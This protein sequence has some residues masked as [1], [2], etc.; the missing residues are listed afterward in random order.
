[1][2]STLIP[3]FNAQIQGVDSIYRGIKGDTVFE[4]QL[5]VRNKLTQRAV[6]MAALTMAYA[7]AMQDDESYKNATPQEKAMNWFVPLPFINA[8]LRV[9]IPFEI[10]I[11]TKSIPEALYNAGFGD[12]SSKETLKALR[13]ALL[14][15]VPSPI[16]TA[17]APILEL[18]TNYSFFRDAPI[19][20]QRDKAVA[21]EM[22]YRENT[23]ELAKLMGKVT[24]KVGVSPVQLEHFVRGYTSTAGI[25]AM[26]MFNPVLR[27]FT[28]E[29]RG[30]KAEKRIT[31]APF[32]GAAFQPDT[33]RGIID[34]VYDD[35]QDW[36][37]AAGT[38]KRLVEE[39]R[40]AEA[41]AYA[42]KNS[43]EIALSSTGGSFRQMMG[44]IA[45]MRRAIE[46]A[47]DMSAKEKRDRIEDLKKYQIQL[48]TKIREMSRMSE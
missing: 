5:D 9:P 44:E 34:S 38:F 31:E 13:T 6:L 23:T 2:M 42:D 48:A 25:L 17:A 28:A 32:F 39:G 18:S 4:K 45:K 24:G 43:R 47:P 10:G 8:S 19:E 14:M 41:R 37:Q 20:T 21:P 30:E 3:F 15:S 1:M 27:P 12:A 11:L 40:V 7:L 33:G 35:V 16:P 29:E 26:S 46:A 22:R 36:Q